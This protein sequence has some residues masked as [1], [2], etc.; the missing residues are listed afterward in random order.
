[1]WIVTEGMWQHHWCMC[2]SRN[3]KYRIYANF[4][5][6]F[7]L[8]FSEEKLG[9]AHYLKQGW[10]CSTSKEMILS[11]VK[12]WSA[13]HVLG[14]LLLQ[15]LDIARSRQKKSL[16]KLKKRKTLETMQQEERTMWAKVVFVTGAKN[17]MLLEKNSNRGAFSNQKQRHLELEKRLCN[18]MNDKRQWGCAVK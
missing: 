10:Y 4:P 7:Y 3:I 1:M 13:N 5:R 17:K 9:C 18:Y 2:V 14:R 11:C 8:E 12:E 6:I 15:D 16:G